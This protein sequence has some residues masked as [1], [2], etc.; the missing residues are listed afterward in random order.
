MSSQPPHPPHQRFAEALAS[1]GATIHR[2]LEKLL[3]PAAVTSLPVRRL[4]P[5][6]LDRAVFVRF[7]VDDR[8]NTRLMLV[9]NETSGALLASALH[10]R[11]VREL[12]EDAM[13]AL[14]ELANIVT[15]SFLNGLSHAAR[16]RLLPTVPDVQTL[17]PEDARAALASLGA[18]AYEATFEATFSQARARLLF[19]AAADDDAV[20]ELMSLLVRGRPAG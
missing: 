18:H 13:R 7:R 4:V 11:H 10:R 2:A 17:D 19:V 15:S 3:A 1:G 5:R 20:D 12:D 16:L 9:A 8:P 14:T 6:S